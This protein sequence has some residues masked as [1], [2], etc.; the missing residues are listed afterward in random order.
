M[1]KIIRIDRDGVGIE[2]SFIS[3]DY[4]MLPCSP[5]KNGSI[6]EKRVSNRRGFVELP[7]QFFAKK[8]LG[9][10]KNCK[11]DKENQSGRN[12]GSQEVNGIH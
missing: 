10:G 9:T 4:T 3:Q 6:Y 7:L 12:E 2:L 5:K 11:A 8:M 1:M